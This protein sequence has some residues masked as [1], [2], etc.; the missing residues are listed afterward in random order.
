MTSWIF[1]VIAIIGAIASGIGAFKT[2]ASA[3]QSDRDQSQGRSESNHHPSDRH[4][5]NPPR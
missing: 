4:P 5:R 3:R 1:A 2:F